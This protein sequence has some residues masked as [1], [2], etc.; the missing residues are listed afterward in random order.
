MK[1]PLPNSCKESHINVQPHSFKQVII[2]QKLREAL[3]SISLDKEEKENAET[4]SC[5]G[6]VAQEYCTLQNIL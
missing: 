5:T 3:L 6:F 1:F 2:V 4:V